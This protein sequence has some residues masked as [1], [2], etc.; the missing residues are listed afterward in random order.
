MLIYRKFGEEFTAKDFRTWTGT[1]LAALALHAMESFD[2]EAQAKKNVVQAIENVAKRLGN[3]PA[4]IKPR[5]I[6][7]I[8]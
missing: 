2:G 4:V 3:T 6:C 8:I 1:A 5:A 7:A